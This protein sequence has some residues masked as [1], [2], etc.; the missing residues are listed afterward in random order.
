MI[1]PSEPE[2]P[3]PPSSPPS[4][5]STELT[6]DPSLDA[7][8]AAALAREGSQLFHAALAFGVIPGVSV[9]LAGIG[10][11]RLRGR[12]ERW[13]RRI[14][15]LGA[16][17]VLVLVAMLATTTLAAREL[18]SGGLAPPSTSATATPTPLAM[19]P[20]PRIGVVLDDATDE[21]AGARVISV[22]PGS[23]AADAGI[24][25]EDRI[26]EVDGV[27]V[28]DREALTE[29]I[30][31]GPLAPRTLVLRR[32]AESLSVVATPVAGPFRPVP[33]DAA[34]CADALPDRDATLAAFESPGTWVGLGAVAAVVL[35]LFVW[36]H[37][38]A[39]AWSETAKVVVPFV[40]VLFGGPT[41]G[42][43]LAALACP[44]L[45]SWNVRFETI[46][47][48]VSE[49]VL[50]AM[51]LT[52]LAYH[53]G[54]GPS[55]ADR[56]PRLGYARTVAQG[57]LYVLAWMPRAL[58]LATPLAIFFFAEG[59]LDEAPVAELVSGA[60]RTPL[61]AVLT[62]VA[63]AVLA[64]IAEESLFRGVLAPHLARLTEAFPAV[65][66]TAAIFGVLHIGGHG[67]LFIGPMFLGAILGWA[68][69]RSRGLA[70]PITLHM[71]L[72]GS[73]MLIALGLGL[74]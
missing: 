20:R 69:L 57:A 43:L 4:P 51:A 72:N 47:I 21:E 22:A 11:M 64:P 61:D 52:L 37:R 50:T 7:R 24:A 48:F 29:A 40:G 15:A 68:R 44:L 23:P 32:G 74:E 10:W 53:R 2:P 5:P 55:L 42:G 1:P 41:L 26:V 56:E 38:R 65:L 31:T 45:V 63:A 19:G 13:A 14:L 71:M 33:L 25:A 36:G 6:A 17:D 30:A 60:G 18:A 35:A 39:L 9:I 34:R 66:V 12:E 3:T 16:L 54:L 59:A 8:D 46:E 62:F 70:A 28:A 58:T 73:A 27:P 67:P 49:I